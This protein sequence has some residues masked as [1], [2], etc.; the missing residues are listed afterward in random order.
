MGNKDLLVKDLSDEII[1]NI[2]LRNTSFLS[3]P[4]T[5]EEQNQGITSKATVSLEIVKTN[6]KK[7]FGDEKEANINIESILSNNDDLTLCRYKYNGVYKT[8]DQYIMIGGVIGTFSTDYKLVKAETDNDYIYLYED[9]SIS[10]I[11]EDTTSNY[12]I[13]Y[14]YKNNDGDYTFYRLQSY[15]K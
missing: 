8:I 15:K 9:V 14:T 3:S 10:M 5:I 7:I 12:T 2:A 1:L 13:K 11:D 6:I 4:V